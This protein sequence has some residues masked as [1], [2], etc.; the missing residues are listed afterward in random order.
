MSVTQNIRKGGGN[1]TLFVCA[2]TAGSVPHSASRSLLSPKRYTPGTTNSPRQHKKFPCV[3]VAQ[4]KSYFVLGSVSVNVV[5]TPSV[6]LT[7]MLPPCRSTPCLTIDSPSPVPPILREW[8]LSARKNRSNILSM[9]S[10]GMP[11]PVSETVTVTS[12]SP[13]ATLMSARPPS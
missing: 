13:L 7:V 5:P 4:G 6:L 2:I 8:L 9:H 11:M 12:F 1:S 3:L 10:A